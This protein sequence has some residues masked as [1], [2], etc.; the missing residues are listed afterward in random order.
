M[1]LVGASYEF[2]LGMGDLKQVSE[3]LLESYQGITVIQASL[4]LASWACSNMK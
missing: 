1:N 4:L 3:G 2:A